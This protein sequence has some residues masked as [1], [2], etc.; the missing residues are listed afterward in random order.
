M[1][2]W[3]YGLVDAATR[4]IRAIVAQVAATIASVWSTVVT[5]ISRWRGEADVW[6]RNLSGLMPATLRN[7]LAVYTMLR[8]LLTVFI[9]NMVAQGVGQAVAWA[10]ARIGEARDLLLAELAALRDWAWAR[11]QDAIA[12]V[13]RVI[14]WAQTQF[15]E[16]LADL[17]RVI[18]HVFGPLG[19]P[20]RLVAWILGALISALVTWFMDNVDTLAAEAF[21]RRRGIEDQAL[22]V[23]GRI[24][25][26]IL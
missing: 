17:R 4:P 1:Y 25:D 13:G 24:V 19:S 22:T 14:D 6:V 21:R 7:A 20:E 15:G 23:V 16:I 3:I 26:R 8:Y 11:I 12:F 10:A 18:D 9:P 5:T 2:D